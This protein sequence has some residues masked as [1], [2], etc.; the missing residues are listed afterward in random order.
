MISKRSHYLYILLL[1]LCLIEQD[2][3]KFENANA[4]NSL[5]KKNHWDW[6]KNVQNVEQMRSA[7]PK[8]WPKGKFVSDD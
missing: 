1:L 8:K 4:I 6:K 2:Q 7:V 3:I 5:G